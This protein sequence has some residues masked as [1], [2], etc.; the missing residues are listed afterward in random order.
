MVFDRGHE[1]AAPNVY[2]SHTVSQPQRLMAEVRSLRH[3][4]V[5]RGRWQEADDLVERALRSAVAH[6]NELN[7]PDLAGLAY[8]PGGGV[9]GSRI[10]DGSFARETVESRSIAIR[11]LSHAN[12]GTDRAE[13]VRQAN[14]VLSSPGHDDVGSFWAA[15]VTLIHADELIAA[16]NACHRADNRSV[17]HR[18]VLALLRARIC[19]VTGETAKA[20]STFRRFLDRGTTPHLT[21][22]ATAWLVEALSDLG[23]HKQ[24]LLALHENGF[25]G[26]GTNHPERTQLLAARS[27]AHITAGNFQLGLEDAL[28]CG[29]SISSWGVHN[30]AV[31]PWRSRAARCALAQGRSGLATVLAQQEYE[32]AHRWGTARTRGVALH[33]LGIARRGTDGVELLLQAESLMAAFPDAPEAARV[34]YHLG[35]ML[36]TQGRWD[37]AKRF[38]DAVATAGPQSRSAYAADIMRRMSNGTP[39]PTLTNQEKS[40]AKLALAGSTNKEVAHTLHLTSRTVEF[41]L[42]NIY[43]KLG[44][45]GRDELG[46]AGLLID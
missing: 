45:S 18:D 21:G 39:M 9:L 1:M 46:L 35:C 12:R 26:A 31:A 11:A 33:A 30:P 5:C 6:A 25:D 42:S 14:L 23:D 20:V 2:Y 22:L 43:R 41:H 17:E 24:A 28:A 37:E 13:A 29:E 8:L 16:A 44:I 34:R 19:A 38:L 15:V 7:G 32:L 4:L 10:P 27:A 36:L 40:V 3:D